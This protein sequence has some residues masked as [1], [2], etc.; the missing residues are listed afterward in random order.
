MALLT[1]LRTLECK[2]EEG[3]LSG[4]YLNCEV[5]W[6]ENLEEGGEVVIEDS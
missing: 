6:K 2:R 5:G 3:F 4:R 1:V